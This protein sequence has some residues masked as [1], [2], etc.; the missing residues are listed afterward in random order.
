MAASSAVVVVGLDEAGCGP[1]LGSLCA[2][3]VHLTRHV[4]GLADSKKLSEARR[5]R[6]RDAI[7]AASHYGIGTVTSAEIDALGLGEA[8]RL[9]F[10]RALEHYMDS[11][12]PAPTWL[13]VDGTIFRPWTLDGV[14]VPHR[15]TPGADARIPCVSAASILAKTTRDREVRDLCD[16]HPHLDEQYDLRRNKGYLTKRHLE[17]LRLHGL[18]QWHRHSFRIRL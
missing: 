12:G 3:A 17:G 14:A 6:L 18:S 15:A 11:G 7:V 5:E 13:E 1:G 16:A 2:A 10:E 4:E 9:V 8:R